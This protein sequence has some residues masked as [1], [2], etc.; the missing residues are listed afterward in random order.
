[1]FSPTQFQNGFIS[2]SFDSWSFAFNIAFH[3]CIRDFGQPCPNKWRQQCCWCN[4]LSS[5]NREKPPIRKAKVSKNWLIFYHL[6]LFPSFLHFWSSLKFFIL[7]QFFIFIY[8]NLSVHLKSIKNAHYTAKYFFTW[9][10]FLLVLLWNM[11]T[12]RA[13]FS[14]KR[15]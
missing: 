7:P 9:R 4:T 11:K 1:M 12:M 3:S 5:G 13:N 2:S 15:T 10:T 6:Q 8:W 14:N